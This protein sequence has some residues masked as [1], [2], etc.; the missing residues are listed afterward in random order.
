MRRIHYDDDDLYTYFVCCDDG[1]DDVD[2]DDD[3]CDY[4]YCYL[5]LPFFL[6]D[7]Y[8]GYDYLNVNGNVNVMIFCVYFCTLSAR[9][10]RFGFQ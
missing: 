9:M 7:G 10:M 3:G 8:D 5:Y 6:Y 1:D 4:D 2:V